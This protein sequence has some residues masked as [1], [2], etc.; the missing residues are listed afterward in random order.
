[1]LL[2]TQPGGQNPALST[3]CTSLPLEG[4]ESGKRGEGGA[5]YYSSPRPFWRKREINKVDGMEK[6][7]KRERRGEGDGEGDHTHTQS[8]LLYN[9]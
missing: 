9:I 4:G 7:T 6:K 1:M 2:F 5:A 3:Y 8:L